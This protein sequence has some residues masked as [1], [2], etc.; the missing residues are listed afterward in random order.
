ML[1]RCLSYAR[2]VVLECS[3]GDDKS[4][5]EREKLDPRHPKNPLNDGRQNLCKWQGRGYLP[6]CKIVSKSA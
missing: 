2:T 4:L 3:K 6:T 1:A 5:R